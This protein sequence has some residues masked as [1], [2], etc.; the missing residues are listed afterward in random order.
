MYKDLIFCSIQ[1]YTFQLYTETGLFQTVYYILL[2]ILITSLDEFCTR[3]EFAFWD[4]IKKQ[5]Y[6]VSESCIKCDH[7]LQ[8]IGS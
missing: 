8:N 4:A 3:W 5:M 1:V 7:N 2:Q 6:N